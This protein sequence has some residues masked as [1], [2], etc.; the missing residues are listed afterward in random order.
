MKRSTTAVSKRTPTVAARVPAASNEPGRATSTRPLPNQAENLR[1]VANETDTFSQTLSS[2][3]TPVN[4]PRS[5]PAKKQ[6]ISQ[7]PSARTTVTT[8][9]NQPA[10]STSLAEFTR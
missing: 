10:Q 2:G 6:A 7:A 1:A 5:M 8:P 4:Q 9:P 3:K